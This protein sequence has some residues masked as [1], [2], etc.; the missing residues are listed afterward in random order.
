MATAILKIRRLG[1]TLQALVGIAIAHDT[2]GS[3]K[4]KSLVVCPAT[5]MWHWESEIKKYFPCGKVFNVLCLKGSPRERAALLQDGFRTANLV[6]VSYAI[7]RSDIDSV[8]A[9]L[10]NWCVCI[11]D[12]GHLLKNPQSGKLDRVYEAWVLSSFISL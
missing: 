12:E 8:S 11:L 6:V 10:P 3:E 1:K 2:Q 9:L 4:A 7:L 5:L